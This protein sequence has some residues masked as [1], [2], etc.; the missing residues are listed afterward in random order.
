MNAGNIF[1]MNYLERKQLKLVR[2]HLQ[3]FTQAGPAESWFSD[4]TLAFGDCKEKFAAHRFMLALRSPYFQARF[5]N[6]FIDSRQS[7]MEVLG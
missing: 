7:V 5:N 1:I 2:K 4:V 6:L 3:K